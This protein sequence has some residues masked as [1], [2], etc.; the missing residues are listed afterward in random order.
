MFAFCGNLTKINLWWIQLTSK[1][2][3][4]ANSGRVISSSRNAIIWSRVY[5]HCQGSP[6]LYLLAVRVFFRNWERKADVWCFDRVG[7]CRGPNEGIGKLWF[8]NSSP[9]VLQDLGVWTCSWSPTIM[10]LHF[11]MLLHCLVH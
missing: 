2:P 9:H 1:C 8:Q 3:G 4:K 11:L 7:G 6:A 10:G 5:S